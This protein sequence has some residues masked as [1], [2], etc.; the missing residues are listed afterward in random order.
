MVAHPHTESED[1]NTAKFRPDKGFSGTDYGA[2]AGAKRGEG[3]VQFEKE[4]ED[5]F[6]LDQVGGRLGLWLRRER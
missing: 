4:A 6:G 2:A 1:V 3:P 5:P